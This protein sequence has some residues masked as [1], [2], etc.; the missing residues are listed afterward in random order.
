MK[1][2]LSYKRPMKYLQLLILLVLLSYCKT[3]PVDDIF[4]YREAIS[5]AV[6]DHLVPG[7]KVKC[8][9]VV[10][11]NT[12][13]WSSGPEIF[14]RT[15]GQESHEELTSEV[16]C[17]A[18]NPI[19][20]SLWAGTYSSGLARISN[21]EVTYFTKEK[22]GLP[23]DLIFHIACDS[24][25][26]VWFNSSAHL[27]GG[28]GCFSDG[29]FQFF[30][31]DNSILPD[32]LIK[33]IACSAEN[34]FVATGG[35]VTQQ[36]VVKISNGEWMLLPIEGYYLMDMDISKK[37][38]LYV[39]DDVSLSSLATMTNKIFRFR[40]DIVVNIL[41]EESRFYSHPYRLMA[42][43]RDYLWLAKFSSGDSQNL[44]V[45]DGER[46]QEPPEGFP[47]I[48]INHMAVDRSNAIWLATTNGIYILPQ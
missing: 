7:K 11:N 10:D 6:G 16:L 21:G 37:G 14:I 23:R 19:D 35:T 27:L 20:Q 18:R 3:G 4:L 40:N 1:I 46:W 47:D 38:T 33:D 42:D 24:R 34:V 32:N 8:L 22:D 2:I 41:P 36:K 39:I 45:F 12:Y 5:F 25:G 13:S 28:L 29:T 44:A 43:L 15:R 9:E 31:P 17:I 30:T 48:L 26:R